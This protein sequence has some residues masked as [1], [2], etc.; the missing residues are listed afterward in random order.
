MNQHIILS[1]NCYWCL[2]AIFQQLKGIENIK[3]GM[4][5]IHNYSYSFGAG[6]KVEAISFE[7]QPEKISLESIMDVFYMAH[8]PTLINWES[9]SFFPLCRSAVFV[10]DENQKT[11]VNK[12]I[13]EYKKQFSDPVQTK[14]DFISPNCFK[15][16]E[17]KNRNY[18]NN[19]RK[20]GYCTSI[21]DPKLDKLRKNFA[22]LLKNN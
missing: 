20:D 18:Y 11:I 21:V 9:D 8:N 13:E 17:E 10:I 12:K 14:I 5:H 3:S 16:V 7:Y 1:G 19:N 15:E 2:E 22:H 6:D 4:Y